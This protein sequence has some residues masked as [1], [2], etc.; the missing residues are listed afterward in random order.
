MPLENRLSYN[1]M[2]HKLK[3]NAKQIITPTAFFWFKTKETPAQFQA[4]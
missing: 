2:A 4:L 1:E 3:V